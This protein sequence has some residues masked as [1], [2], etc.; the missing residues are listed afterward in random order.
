MLIR[1][2][3]LLFYGFM[4]IFMNFRAGLLVISAL[5]G[6][7]M[8]AASAAGA[9]DSKLN[10]PNHVR[11]QPEKDRIGQLPGGDAEDFRRHMLS[12]K[13]SGTLQSAIRETKNGRSAARLT[14][15]S[16]FGWRSDPIKG[17]RRKHQGIDLPGPA[18][19]TIY[20]TG[21]GVVTIAQAVGGYGNLVEISHPGG[22]RTRYGHLSR[23]LVAVGMPVEQGQV[24]GQMG[25]TGRST[26]T[27]LHYEVRVNGRAV[28]PLDFIGTAAPSFATVWAPE[29]PAVARWVGWEETRGAGSLPE[30]RIR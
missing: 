23:V 10:D 1:R 21:Q 14:I 4:R 28:D 15:S 2:L 24:I 5:L 18:R 29:K 22:V 7:A 11:A 17:I 13:G 30:S 20:S 25:S 16:P 9:A 3:P 8:P 6:L 27:H 26:G 19:A 12:W